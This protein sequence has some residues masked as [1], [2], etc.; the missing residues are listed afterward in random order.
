MKGLKYL[1]LNLDAEI[2][3]DSANRFGLEAFWQFPA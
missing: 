2:I 1:F 3:I